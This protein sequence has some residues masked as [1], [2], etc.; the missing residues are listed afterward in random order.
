MQANSKNRF[1]MRF[2]LGLESR[3]DAI[4]GFLDRKLPDAPVE[5][6]YTNSEKNHRQMIVDQEIEEVDIFGHHV[7]LAEHNRI[8]ID[9]KIFEEN[10]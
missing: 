8:A 9:T 3:V 5:S 2:I 4:Y 1:F 10:K 7:W 6:E